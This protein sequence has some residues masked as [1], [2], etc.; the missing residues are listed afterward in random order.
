MRQLG[1]RAFLRLSALGLGGM[2]L[3]ACGATPTPQVVEKVVERE[4]TKI[5]EGTPQ[6]VK[7]TVVVQ[8][9]VVVE[10]QVEVTAAPAEVITLRFAEGSW[11]G[12]EGIKFWTDDIIPR[13][14]LENPGIKAEFESAEAPEWEQKVFAQMVAGDAPDVMFL[15]ST[16]SLNVIQKK[17]ALKLNDYFGPDYLDSFYPSMVAGYNIDGE[18]WGMPKYVASWVMGYNKDIL[19]A[20]GVAYPD[21]NWTWDDYSIALEKCTQ[22]DADGNITQGGTYVLYDY[23]QPWVWMNGGQWTN[24]VV[25]ADRCLIDDP[26]TLEALRFQ[27]DKL[28]GDNRVSFLPGSVPDM[29]WWNVFS[30]GKVAFMESASWTVTNYIRENNFAWD[31][32]VYPSLNGKRSTEVFI[33]GYVA[34][35]GTPYPRES[36]KLIEFL[37]QPWAA[38]AMCLGILGLQ[39]ARYDT[40]EAWDTASMGAQAGYNVAAFTKE[41]DRSGLEPTYTDTGKANELFNP[42]WEQI[43]VTQET[44]LEE[45]VAE[46]VAR[47]NE[48]LASA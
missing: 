4:V 6:V 20:A 8:E 17:Q 26:K 29:G 40:V 45:G 33:N 5:V 2:A 24:K 14:E 10:K 1:R 12:P 48:A 43:W 28:Y 36:A 47:I 32:T 18:L 16:F 37:T 38:R 35:A 41:M 11:V 21:E 30:S 22:R 7:E 23:L 19:D 31:F 42:I 13:F 46:I 44:T 25:A 39:P 3:A 34:Y 9:T 15:W 27:Y